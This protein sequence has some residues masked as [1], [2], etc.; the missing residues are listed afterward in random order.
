[1]QTVNDFMG[2][3]LQGLI[4]SIAGGVYTVWLINK[5]APGVSKM[6]QRT[7]GNMLGNWLLKLF[8]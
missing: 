7:G 1:M 6:A 3:L 8:R 5:K 2:Y 4:I